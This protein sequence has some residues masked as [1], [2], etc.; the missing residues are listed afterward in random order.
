MSSA[1]VVRAPPLSR[2]AARA[3]GTGAHN[4]GAARAKAPTPQ[5][6]RTSRRNIGS[7]LMVSPPARGAARR[8]RTNYT[9]LHEKPQSG[10]PILLARLAFR[11]VGTDLSDGLTVQFCIE[12]GK[13][14]HA[15]KPRDDDGGKGVAKHIDR[16]EGR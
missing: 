12:G 6:F 2:D 3:R 4:D 10:S 1:I 11:W 8:I 7:K 9:K 15:L 5:R 16:N 13:I 14:Y